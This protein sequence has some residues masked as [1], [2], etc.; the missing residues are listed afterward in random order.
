MRDKLDEIMG[1]LMEALNLSGQ[2]SSAEY[3]LADA[4]RRVILEHRIAKELS[5]AIR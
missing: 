1:D 5:R 4:L 2:L 3:D